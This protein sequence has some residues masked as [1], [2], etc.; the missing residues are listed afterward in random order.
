MFEVIS[1]GEGDVLTVRPIIG[2][3]SKGSF[4][5]GSD[6]FTYE[7]GSDDLLDDNIEGH[8]S[9]TA[10]GF[11]SEHYE[12]KNTIAKA[13]GRQMEQDNVARDLELTL[14][15]LEY[16][17]AKTFTNGELYYPRTFA[18]LRSFWDHC[19]ITMGE[20]M[21]TVSDEYVKVSGEALNKSVLPA[22]L[23][24]WNFDRLLHRGNAGNCSDENIKTNI[25]KIGQVDGINVYSFN[26]IFEPTIS[27]VGVMAQELLK[28]NKKNIVYKEFDGIYRVNYRRLNLSFN[29]KNLPYVL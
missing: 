7:T 24:T 14:K 13:S 17:N 21:P 1:K 29:G 20:L 28:S 10:E 12:M 16:L 3:G 11:S 25:K 6:E 9:F 8:S 15:E 23:R 19:N 27:R 26:Y 4:K 18:L 2:L 5:I 22:H